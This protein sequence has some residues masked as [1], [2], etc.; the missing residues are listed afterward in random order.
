[1]EK[2]VVL[3][4]AI[5]P[6]ENGRTLTPVLSGTPLTELIS[7]FEREHGFGPAGGYGG[8][9]PKSFAYGPLDCYFMGQAAD[10][11]WEQGYYLLGCGQCGEVDCWPLIAR[12]TK[13]GDTVV[14]NRFE[15]PH[16]PNRDY[17]SFGP[18]I[19]DA[20]QYKSAVAEIASQFKSA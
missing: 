18:F 19:F 12:I 6:L 10:S 2:H 4:F 20:E 11:F 13:I 17:S 14:W 3:S 1:M 5:Q 16:R 8:L 15:Q 7:Q 9:I